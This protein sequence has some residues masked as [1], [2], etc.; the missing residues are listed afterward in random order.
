M[1]N[2][3]S[4]SEIAQR[5]MT[6]Q[7]LAQVQDLILSGAL[8]PGSKINQAE[9]A[10]RFATSLVPVREALARLQ[11]SGLVQIVP[12]R[13]AFVAGLSVE[14]MVDI[15]AM[16]E[17][18][19]EQAAQE[20]ARRFSDSDIAKIEALVNQ[21]EIAASTEAFDTFLRLNRDL[22]FTIYRAAGRRHLLQVIEQLWNQSERYRRLQI[23]SIPQRVEASL[24]ENQLILAACHQR[25]A[26]SLGSIVRY[27][28]HQTKVGLLE[29]MQ[30]SWEH[31]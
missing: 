18:L 1:L 28:V 27:K 26:E 6:E 31:P 22:H 21:I 3:M 11:S 15:Y 19:E 29:I 10:Q 16:R 24:S 25:D 7:V 5:T 9:L 23:H 14:E 13:G 8:E 30:S 17:V 4:M 12:H 20:A 2:W